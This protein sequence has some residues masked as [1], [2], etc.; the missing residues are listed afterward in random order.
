MC[1]NIPGKVILIKG[2]SAK[3]KQKRHSH[4]VDVSSLGDKVK[5][6]DYLTTYQ[7]VAINKISAKDAE[8]ILRLVNGAS[9]TR[10]KSS[11]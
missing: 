10:V 8:E 9:D 11:N 5:K 3:V 2:K 6:G 4:W 7:G 1:I